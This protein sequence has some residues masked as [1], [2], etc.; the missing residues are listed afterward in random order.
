MNW[1]NSTNAKEI[2]TLYLIFSVFAGMVG[3]AFSV[4]IRLELSSPGV[5]FLQGDHQLFN[6]IISAHAFIMIF[7]MVI[8]QHNYNLI[9]LSYNMQSRQSLDINYSSQ[10][11]KDSIRHPSYKPKKEPHK[12]TKI[13]IPNAFYNR[14]EIASAA[15][16][17]KGVYIFKT[18]TGSCYV[19]SS[20]SLYNRV[21]SYF[22]PSILAKGDRRVLRYFHKYGF[23]D[24]SLTLYILEEGSTSKMAVELEQYFID[25]LSPDLNVELVASSTGYHEP[26]SMEW[27]LYLRELR[28]TPIYVYDIASSNLI[29]MFDSKTNLYKILKMD[30]RT[31]DKYLASG[32]PFLNRFIF[33]LTAITKF[34]VEALLTID[35]LQ[36][37]FSQERANKYSSINERSHSILAENI[38]NH[39]LSSKFPS[40]NSCAK[41]LKADRA[42]LRLYLKGQSNQAYFRGQ[43]KLSY[44]SK[45]L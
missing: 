41:V 16:K 20:I 32:K 21:C 12:Y 38:K 30:H 2:G 15:K 25:T 24:V 44:V 3:T 18:S 35:D 17:A 45:Q 36:R 14:F 19:G 1:L 6:V 43:W 10:P 29:H 9:K 42:T 28:G 23:K 37:L 5:Q 4:L 31:L 7:F 27:R 33:S 26:M 11:A 39:K 13:F 34:S 22:M 40:L 8:N